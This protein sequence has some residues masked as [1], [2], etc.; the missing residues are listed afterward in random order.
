ML[1]KNL[2]QTSM[3]SFHDTEA[4]K[5]NVTVSASVVTLPTGRMCR[6]TAGTTAEWIPANLQCDS[7]H[8]YSR[9]PRA[10]WIDTGSP[11]AADASEF[12]GVRS[13]RPPAERAELP[14]AEIILDAAGLNIL[15]RIVEER[16]SARLALLQ[17]P[18]SFSLE[19]TCNDASDTSAGK[20]DG[21]V[22]ARQAPPHPDGGGGLDWERRVSQLQA[23]WEAVRQDLLTRMDM[24]DSR[25][26]TPSSRRS[27]STSASPTTGCRDFAPLHDDDP[28]RP[29]AAPCAVPEGPWDSPHGPDALHPAPDATAPAHADSDEAAA[30]AVRL[31]PGYD[32]GL[33]WESLPSPGR[34]WAECGGAT[35]GTE[36]Q[37]AVGLGVGVG[38]EVRRCKCISDPGCRYLT[39]F[40][41]QIPTNTY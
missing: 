39:V 30:A 18:G 12:D 5:G 38:V 14:L 15:D 37:A 6:Q 7:L 26:G 34:P 2:S 4:G 24:V 41:K 3:M 17:K 8:S 20:G 25:S 40:S 9:S 16:V 31:A 27:V 23:E 33:D 28:P 29:L 10:V 22:S 19:T 36:A 32:G 21:P 35:G 13:N 11:S 1:S